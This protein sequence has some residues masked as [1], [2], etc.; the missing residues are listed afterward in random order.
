MVK[1]IKLEG[2]IDLDYQDN[3]WNSDGDEPMLYAEVK[4]K[5]KLLRNV[6]VGEDFH[7]VACNGGGEIR[8]GSFKVLTKTKEVS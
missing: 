4:G 1:T 5:Q 7:L 8:V 6:K 3:T 2:S